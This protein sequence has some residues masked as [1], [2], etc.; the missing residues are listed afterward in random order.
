MIIK[1]W[2]QNGQINVMNQNCTFTTKT[3]TERER[4]RAIGEKKLEG[5][6]KFVDKSYFMGAYVTLKW[7]LI[8]KSNNNLCDKKKTWN[9]NSIFD[10]ENQNHIHETR[11]NA[12]IEKYYRNEF[13]LKFRFIWWFNRTMFSSYFVQEA[14]GKA[15]VF[16]VCS[17]MYVR[18]EWLWLLYW[19]MQIFEIWTECKKRFCKRDRNHFG[20]GLFEYQNVLIQ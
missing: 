16:F 11:E 10:D 4:E 6:L 19:H 12:E 17:C 13:C 2:P 18:I 3:R 7:A 14:L 20:C 9:R 1:L 15:F 5:V 8:I